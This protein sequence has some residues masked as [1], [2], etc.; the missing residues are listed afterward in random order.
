ML[1]TSFAYWLVGLALSCL[2]GLCNAL[3]SQGLWVGLIFGLT[4]AAILL[5]LRFLLGA[6]RTWGDRNE[7]FYRG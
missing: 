1:I 7:R 3:G 6:C 4:L 2:L 5:S